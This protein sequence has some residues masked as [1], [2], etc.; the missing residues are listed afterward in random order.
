V[1]L[2][3]DLGASVGWI[4]ELEGHYKSSR[5]LNNFNTILLPNYFLADGRIG[6]QWPRLSLALGVT[7]ILNKKYV[8]D[9]DL[10]NGG[11]GFPAPPRRIV[12]EM[13]TRF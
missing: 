8:T 1:D 12:G 13:S 4:V 6:W 9:G 11:F 10:T 3:V 7:N 2:G 5:Y